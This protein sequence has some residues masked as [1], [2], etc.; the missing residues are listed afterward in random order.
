MTGEALKAWRASLAAEGARVS[1]REAAA[2]LD[3]PLRSYEDWEAG[4]R[5]TPRLM[6]LACAAVS[7]GL[8][9]W[10]AGG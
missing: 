9:P 10:R 5:P 2:R 8:K 3:V 7:H 1:Q 4:R 6:P